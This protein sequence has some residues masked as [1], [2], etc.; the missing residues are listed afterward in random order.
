MH[1]LTTINAKKHPRKGFSLGLAGNT[2]TQQRLALYGEY[3]SGSLTIE[4]LQTV[5]L[6]V[7]AVQ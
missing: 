4:R 1:R 2:H 5:A 6:R 3:R 7:I